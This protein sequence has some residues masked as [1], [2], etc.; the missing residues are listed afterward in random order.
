MNGC[1]CP[2]GLLDERS[3]CFGRNSAIG[4]SVNCL[5]LNSTEFSGD[6]PFYKPY[7]VFKSEQKKYGGLIPAQGRKRKYE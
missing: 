5:I 1:R 6:C 2:Y 4:V 3:D 7:K